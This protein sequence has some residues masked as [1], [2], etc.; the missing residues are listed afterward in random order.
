MAVKAMA[1]DIVAVTIRNFD[2]RKSLA[3]SRPLS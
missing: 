2:V 1:I 3:M